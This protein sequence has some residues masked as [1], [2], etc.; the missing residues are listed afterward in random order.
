[1]AT[2]DF[3][4]AGGKYVIRNFADRGEVPALQESV[5]FNCTGLGGVFRRGDSSR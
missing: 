5:I 4:L 3:Q 2:A 1:M